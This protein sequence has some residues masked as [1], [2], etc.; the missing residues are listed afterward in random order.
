M[1]RHTYSI[2]S[3]AWQRLKNVPGCIP[4]ASRGEVSV[5]EDCTDLLAF[6]WR[7][8]MPR[9]Y[10]GPLPHDLHPHQAANVQ[11]VLAN[12]G[13]LIGD[14]PGAGKTRTALEV[15]RVLGGPTLVV[16]PALAR[17]TWAVE[18]Q[19]WLGQRLHVVKGKSPATLP[20]LGSDSVVFVNYEVAI[21]HSST[22]GAVQWRCV[23]L[24][25]VHRVKARSNTW[26]A[27]VAGVYWQSTGPVVAL[28]ATPIWSNVIDLW[29]VLSW[30]HPGALGSYKDFARRY[31]GAYLGEYGWQL[32]QPTHTKELNARLA[33]HYTRN[34]NATI[35][36]MS[37]A[38]VTLDASAAMQKMLAAFGLTAARGDELRKMTQDL[39]RL[40]TVAKIDALHGLL[41][42]RQ[43]LIVCHERASV[44][45]AVVRLA[46]KGVTAIALTGSVSPEER[47][48]AFTDAAASVVVAT[49]DSVREALDGRRFER[50]IVVDFPWV[51]DELVQLEGRLTRGQATG[52]AVD[53]LVIENSLDSALF[54][55]L[56]RRL[57][58]RVSVLGAQAQYLA[59]AETLAHNDDARLA[60]LAA[61]IMENCDG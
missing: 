5:G 36:P 59:I 6:E 60:E 28:S 46:A 55:V 14:P 39:R 51:P 4:H 9:S 3:A 50:L 37:R 54:E 31:C 18:T 38:L 42:A 13:A 33:Y 8:S 30:V 2:T 25:E 61:R 44:A 29:R 23:I 47:Q 12:D 34:E 24:D 20:V 35:T 19:R 7:R 22:L 11:F 43:T 15:A 48:R 52:V 16:G 58:E 40:S 41:D 17:G 32:G 1:R 10:N 53:Y 49:R 57:A 56:L 27:G 26:T 45:R 21:A